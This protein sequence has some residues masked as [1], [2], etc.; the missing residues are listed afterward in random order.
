[1]TVINGVEIDNIVYRE[2]DMRRAIENKRAIEPKL[3]VIIVVSNPCQYARRYILARQFQERIKKQEKRVILYTVELSHDQKFHVT[4]R[5]HP[6]HLQVY[7]D[8]APLWHKEN[9]INMGV[10]H[11]LPCDW[12]AF[13]WVDADVEF[14]SPTWARDTLRILNGT[15]DVVQLFSHVVDMDAQEDAMNIFSGFGFQYVKKRRYQ[16]KD[17]KNYWHPGFAWAMT[18]SF[19]KKIGGLYDWNILGAGDHMMCLSFL[20][21][22]RSALNPLTHALFQKSISEFQEKT[23]GLSLGYVPGVIRHFFHGQKKNRKYHDRWKILVKHQYNPETH[24]TR[25]PDGLLIPTV[26]CPQGLLDDILRYFQERNED[27]YLTKGS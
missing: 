7:A 15:C 27:E 13:A 8:T 9:L 20:G 14:D 24:V 12:K 18:R 23:S 19:Y 10:R 1:M 3:H 21:K 26:E 17:I 25:R 6:R 4:R 2:N 11:L 5:G 22:S 16:T